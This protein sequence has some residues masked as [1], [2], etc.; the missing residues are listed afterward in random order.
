MSNTPARSMTGTPVNTTLM[1]RLHEILEITTK[2]HSFKKNPNRKTAPNRRYKPSRQLISD[3]VKYLQAKTNLK[4][5]TPTYTSV[6]AP[7]SL[8][9]RKN[10]CDITGL[11]SNYKSPSNQ[12]RFYNS[13]IYQE[14]VKN[15]PPGVDQ[16]YLQLRGAN[17]VLK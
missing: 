14:V 8:L 17:V 16:E 12:L 10:Y 1:D 2:E 7:P 13:E 9:P 11:P 15:L 6:T 3:E 5:D 4:F